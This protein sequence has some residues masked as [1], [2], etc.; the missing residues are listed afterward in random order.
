MTHH[1]DLV[2]IPLFSD[3]ST[4]QISP[5]LESEKHKDQFREIPNRPPGRRASSSTVRPKTSLVFL[6]VFFFLKSAAID[7]FED[8]PSRGF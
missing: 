6:F 7:A 4:L 1:R 2:I 8:T 5:E 3:F